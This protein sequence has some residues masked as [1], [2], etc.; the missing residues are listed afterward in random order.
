MASQQSPPSTTTGEP[1][2][3][4]IQFKTDPPSAEII[5]ELRSEGV[6][7]DKPLG[8]GVYVCKFTGSDIKDIEG[9]SYIEGVLV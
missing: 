4:I 7:L 2:S 5:Q 6:T 1:R 3:L 9:K 8:L